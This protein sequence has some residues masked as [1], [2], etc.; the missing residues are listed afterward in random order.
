MQQYT[1]IYTRRFQ[2]GSHHNT[3]VNMRRIERRDEETVLAMLKRED[4]EDD[5]VFLFLGHPPLQG[6]T[7]S[8][9]G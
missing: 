9:G 2:I 7:E 5:A 8:E 3:I 6:E 4:I 1:A